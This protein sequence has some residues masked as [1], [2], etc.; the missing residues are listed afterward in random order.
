M[1]ER[2]DD[3][4][5]RLLGAPEPAPASIR[6]GLQL[7]W[8]TVV[9]LLLLKF[10][11]YWTNAAAALPP[12]TNWLAHSI[13]M[14]VVSI[15]VLFTPLFVGQLITAVCLV[16]LARHQRWAR[17]VL[18]AGVLLSLMIAIASKVGRL[19]AVSNLS[20]YVQL[21]LMLVEIF[22]VALFFAESANDW[23][24]RKSR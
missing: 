12:D 7:G 16:L 19:V 18:F 2:S 20:F 9:A 10:W 15:V 14:L 17:L 22:V 8:A 5:A 23:F 1:R 21:V 24:R 6:L 3:G 13:A 4:E 11:P